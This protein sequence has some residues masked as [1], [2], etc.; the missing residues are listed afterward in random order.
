MR[1][2]GICLNGVQVVCPRCGDDLEFEDDAGPMVLEITETVTLFGR[3][4]FIC[5]Q[6][7]ALCASCKIIVDGE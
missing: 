1:T 4:N 2:W 3:E 7:T 6:A 5:H